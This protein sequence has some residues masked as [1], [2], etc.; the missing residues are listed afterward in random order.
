MLVL[1]PHSVLAAEQ[2]EQRLREQ[3]ASVYR[4]TLSATG[5]ESLHG[6]CGMMAG[7]ELYLMGITNIPLTYNGNEMYDVLAV[8]DQIAEGYTPVCYPAETYDLELALNEVSCNGTK[9]VYNILLGFQWTST[10]AGRKFG[11]A[12]V[13]H[14]ILDG[15]VYFTEGFVT[16]FQSDPSQAMV[17]S[18][19]EFVAYYDS[20]TGFEGLI[21]FASGIV[22]AGCDTMACDLY[23]VADSE[24]SLLSKPDFLE[25][26]QCRTVPA[27]ER[28]Y[29]TA[30]CQNMEGVL[31]YQIQE[32]GR[33]YY[34]T[35]GQAK[36]VWF[37]GAQIS[38]HDLEKSGT[39]ISGVVRS[40]SLTIANVAVSVLNQNGETVLY[41]E[42]PA[43]G[44][45]ADLRT[46]GLDL[47]ILD[48]GA[49][50]VQVYCDLENPYA[51]NGEIIRKLSRV[52]AGETTFV[53][54]D[55]VPVSRTVVATDTALKNGWWYENG[56]WIYYTDGEYRTGWFCDN[57]IDY[58][59]REDGTATTGWQEINGKKRYFSET[60]AMRIG[61]LETADGTYY[62]LRNGVPATGTVTVD[63]SEYRFD[64]S[65]LLTTDTMK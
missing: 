57:G 44:M 50:T 52:R 18:I 54:G 39:N 32:N 45:K 58:Y 2:E 19:P 42:T 22:V 40:D 12:T 33:A 62:M 15:M 5:S 13:I 56:S 14:G 27:G 49:Y 37:D 20:W 60:G 24:I 30:L 59:L 17:C 51:I 31:F 35:T 29:A 21:H 9:D 48:D 26:E 38:V 3:I 28:L 23:V 6:Y 64:E 1:L 7:W 8:S 16:P 47:S 34:I 10:E 65:G 36:P 25:A 4:K 43:K 11:H 63:G 46:V 41:R 53:V 61:W 55:A